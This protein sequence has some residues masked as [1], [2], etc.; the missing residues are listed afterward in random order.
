MIETERIG[1]YKKTE[2]KIQEESR[3]KINVC[4]FDPSKI[5][6]D[7]DRLVAA[8]TETA[9]LL[10][11]KKIEELNAFEIF[12]NKVLNKG[13][14]NNF[15]CD[16][17]SQIGPSIGNQYELEET[18]IFL[19]LKDGVLDG[20]EVMMGPQ[21]SDKDKKRV[22]EMLMDIPNHHLCDSCLK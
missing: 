20:L 14:V 21:T 17:A 13:I 1:I 11:E 2:W 12:I 5:K 18:S 10:K 8:L 15:L 3:F 19:P 22:E 7:F 6:T 16:M 4:P 9:S